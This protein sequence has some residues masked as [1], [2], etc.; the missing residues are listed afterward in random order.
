MTPLLAKRRHAV[1]LLAVAFGI[2]S[3]GDD[4]QGDIVNDPTF[5]DWCG[6]S[7][8]SW[9]LDSGHIQQA[10]TWNADD[11]GVAF[12]ERGTEISQVTGENQATCILFTTVANVDPAAAMVLGVDFNNDGVDDYTWAIAGTWTQVQTEITAPAVYDGITFHI[13]K[14]G[15]GTAVLAEMRIQSTT[16]CTAAPPMIMGQP[17]GDVCNSDGECTSGICSDPAFANPS[18]VCAQCSSTH[19][20]AGGGTCTGGPYGFAQCDPGE[21][22]LDTGK[23]CA[24]NS[25]CA[26]GKCDNVQFFGPA[27]VPP[28]AGDA[29]SCRP[30]T[31]DAGGTSVDAGTTDASAGG[32]D[33]GFFAP[34]FPCLGPPILVQG[35]TCD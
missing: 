13:T 22:K 23:P 26:S 12:M 3:L 4:C 15:M 18:Q 2:V 9:T 25:D 5:R 11:L 32:A 10:P 19:P 8:C 31:A 21:H 1:L 35:G 29:A 24:A 27:G 17:L 28:D 7:L 16:G 14:G 33:G 34:T 20:C 30:D 6:D